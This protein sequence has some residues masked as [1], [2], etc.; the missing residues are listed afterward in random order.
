MQTP[1]LSDDFHELLGAAGQIA[2]LAQEANRTREQ[3]L[4]TSERVMA[5][6]RAFSA[7]YVATTTVK[8]PNFRLP[9]LNALFPTAQVAALRSPITAILSASTQNIVASTS[10]LQFGQNITASHSFRRSKIP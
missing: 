2:K 10:L 3:L 9:N 4:E 8:L 1:M 7:S 6:M 5:P